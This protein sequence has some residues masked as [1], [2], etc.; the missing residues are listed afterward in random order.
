ML[1]L[2][3]RLHQ[4]ILTHQDGDVCTFQPSCSHYALEAVRRHGLKG[5]FMTSDRVLRCHGGNHK[6]YPVF[7][8]TAYDPVPLK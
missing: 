2:P 7:D 8:G 4:R 3:I 6:F 5:L 1:I